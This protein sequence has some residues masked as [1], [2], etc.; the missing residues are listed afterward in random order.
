MPDPSGQPASPSSAPAAPP[1]DRRR[2]P[3]AARPRF[4]IGLLVTAVWVM[5]MIQVWRNETDRVGAG[6][7]EMGISPEVI[8]STWI[9]FDQWMAVEQ[10]GKW[11]G[12]G[13]LTIRRRTSTDPDLDNRPLSGIPDLPGFHMNNRTRLSIPLMG[14]LV[15][16]DLQVRVNMNAAFEMDTL[17]TA[18]LLAGQRLDLDAFVED[19]F[20]YYRVRTGKVTAENAPNAPDPAAAGP[21][22]SDP[23][24]AFVDA[25]FGLPQNDVCGRS[26]LDGP[27]VLSDVVLPIMARGEK[28]AEGASWTTRVSN[29][30]Q[31]RL[32]QRID[33]KVEAEE[34]I[35][36]DGEAVECWRLVERIGALQTTVWCDRLGRP[37]RRQL[38][39]GLQMTMTQSDKVLPRDPAIRQDLPMDE[40]IDREWIRTHLD[41]AMADV[42]LETLLAR[43]PRL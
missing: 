1:V 20:L 37:V 2:G 19:G 14:V 11:L 36:V 29:P 28:L 42:P 6:L 15:P 34:T 18:L 22:A 32:D 5:V 7:R 40:A 43:I 27:I 38:A 12:A 35:V 17:Q 4:W 16:L 39:N 31:G 24:A 10:N 13:R 30:L 23:H 8:L 21:V 25:G 33:V 26:P 9:D 41:P 3:I